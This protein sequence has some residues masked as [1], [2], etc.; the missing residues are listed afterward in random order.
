[1][2]STAV[3][4]RQPPTNRRRLKEKLRPAAPIFL[5]FIQTANRQQPY[6]QPPTTQNLT[7]QFNCHLN[8]K[9][10]LNTHST[11]KQETK[12]TN[13]H[14]KYGCLRTPSQTDDALDGA[15]PFH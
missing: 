7:T 11:P 9:Q 13:N 4:G 8:S 3:N 1:L 10:I 2:L 14:V 12:N 15:S 6:Q 5:S